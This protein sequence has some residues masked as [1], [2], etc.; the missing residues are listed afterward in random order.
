[1][2]IWYAAALLLGGLNL[3]AGAT[4]PVGSPLRSFLGILLFLSIA[5]VLVLAGREAR[6]AALRPSWQGALAGICY[7]VPSGLVAVLFPPTLAE[8]TAELRRSHATSY[9]LQA[10]A[11]SD[12]PA[13]HWSGFMIG[14]VVFAVLGLVAGWVG[15]FFGRQRDESGAM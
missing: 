2:Q 10:A 9:Q 15:S 4:L 1:M 5:A 13:A 14:V 8:L 7:A 12:T 6:R 11:L 3:A